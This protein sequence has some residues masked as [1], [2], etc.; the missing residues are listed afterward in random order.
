V[1]VAAAAEETAEDREEISKA[2]PIA[3]IALWNITPT[4]WPN[5]R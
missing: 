2:T 5:R 4:A 3:T 1:V